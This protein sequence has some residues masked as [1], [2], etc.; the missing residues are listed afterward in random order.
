MTLEDELNESFLNIRRQWD[1][2][3]R[4]S[5]STD[6]ALATYQ[7]VMKQLTTAF[8]KKDYATL[9]EV[10]SRCAYLFPFLRNEDVFARF[11]A[12]YQME[13]TFYQIKKSM[14]EAWVMLA[15]DF[16]ESFLDPSK[17]LT[18]IQ[19]YDE[20]QDKDPLLW[21]SYHYAQMRITNGSFPAFGIR[22]IPRHARKQ[23]S[24]LFDNEGQVKSTTLLPPVSDVGD[25]IGKP[26]GQ[27]R[28]LYFA[29]KLWKKLGL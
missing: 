21:L 27:E 18:P 8:Q 6:T 12:N 5:S 4:Q 15:I 29:E 3:Y 9:R 16:A 14:R 28:G 19:N 1:A 24:L 23:Y 2:G 25:T 7:K 26:P 17:L 11:N 20:I 10:T 13:D 22:E